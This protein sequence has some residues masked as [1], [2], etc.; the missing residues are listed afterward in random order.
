MKYIPGHSVYYVDV[1]L[2]SPGD[3][4]TDRQAHKITFMTK[5]LCTKYYLYTNVLSVRVFGMLSLY[6]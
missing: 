4:E 6:E 1:F 3:I 2:V 5:L